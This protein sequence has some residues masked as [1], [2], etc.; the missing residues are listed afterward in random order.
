MS[1]TRL[2]GDLNGEPN[3]CNDMNKVEQVVAKMKATKMT[4]NKVKEMIARIQEAGDAMTSDLLRMVIAKS[5]ED[6]GDRKGE[7]GE[8]WGKNEA[9]GMERGGADKGDS[10]VVV[11]VLLYHAHAKGAVQQD[12]NDYLLAN[13]RLVEAHDFDSSTVVQRTGPAC[14][15]T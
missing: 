10:K 6:G 3:A 7:R 15:P 5:Q 4:D 14:S 11:H 12:V 8:R 2:R 13:P 9:E 1:G